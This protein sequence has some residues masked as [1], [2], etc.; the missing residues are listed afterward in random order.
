MKGKVK[1]WNNKKGYGVIASEGGEDVFVHF[2]EIQGAGLKTLEE[3]EGV[4]LDIVR[5]P[6]GPMAK[7]LRM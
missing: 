5:T 7:N 4:T 3:G 1:W 2:A 6:R